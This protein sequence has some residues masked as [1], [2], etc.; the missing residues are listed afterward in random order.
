MGDGQQT[1][2]TENQVNGGRQGAVVQAGA[3]T[4]GVHL[5]L[6]AD[7]VE[8]AESPIIVTVARESDI[9]EEDQTVVLDTDPPVVRVRQGRF[10]VTVESN[11]RGRAVVLRGMRPVVLSR[12]PARRACPGLPISLVSP[13]LISPWHFSTDLQ[14]AAPRLHAKD[15]NF[16]FSV[17]ATDVEEFIITPDAGKDEVLWHLEMDWLCAGRQGTTVID[18]R[19]QPFALYPRSGPRLDCYQGLDLDHV[20]GCPARRLAVQSTRGTVIRGCDKDSPRGE[21]KPDNGGAILEFTFPHRTPRNE[22]RVEYYYRGQA[23]SYTVKPVSWRDREFLRVTN[24]Q[25]ASRTP[26]NP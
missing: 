17:S 22:R 18:D 9:D 11:V 6:S 24:L 21:I 2:D 4:G 7:G 12:R 20:R 13:R 1:G 14:A 3:I 10:R 15:V 23:V 16:P 25:P 19:G 5:H 26:E 8:D